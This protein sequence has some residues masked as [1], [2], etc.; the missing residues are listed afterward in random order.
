M[1]VVLLEKVGH[2]GGIGTVVSVKDGFARNFLLPR[3][4][5]LRATEKNLEVFESQRQQIEEANRRRREEAQAQAKAMEGA[6]LVVIRQAGESGHLFGSVRNAD[7][8]E[9]A[10]QQGFD[11]QKTQ[12][13]I[14]SPIKTLGIHEVKLMLHPEVELSV[15]VNVAQTEDEA[16]AQL[17]A[18]LNPPAE[19][20]KVAPEK[21]TKDNETEA[22]ESQ[23]SA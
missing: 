22:S 14:Q 3:K 23:E 2:L 18:Y 4:K 17:D 12:V 8:A 6:V 1:K 9:A 20:S 13:M 11:I 7:V 15:K 16:Q 19:D 21:A 5:A 10:C